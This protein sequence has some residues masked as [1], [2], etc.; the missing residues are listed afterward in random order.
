[1]PLQFNEV[2]M[3]KNEFNERVKAVKDITSLFRLERFVYLSIIVSC[4]L[5]LLISI[6]VALIKGQIGA[7]EITTMFGSGGVITVMTGRLL[8][9]WDKAIKLLD[10]KDD[11]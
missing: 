1:M 2:L 11:R 3:A 5:I 8:H 4:L 9:M 6:T 10:K 7:P